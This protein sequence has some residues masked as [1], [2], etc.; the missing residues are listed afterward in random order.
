MFRT[1]IAALVLAI[2]P[3]ALVS[4]HGGGGSGHGGGGGRGVTVGAFGLNGFV[5]SGYHGSRGY[6]LFGL[7]GGYGGMPYYYYENYT[8][9]YSPAAPSIA[10]P[11][12]SVL[13]L[14]GEALATLYL[15]LP[16][17]GEV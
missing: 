1:S 14:S 4:A 3:N 17:A 6:P 16:A 11:E 9:D 2:I 7:W 12:P 5:P 13:N 10:T 8:P 15:E